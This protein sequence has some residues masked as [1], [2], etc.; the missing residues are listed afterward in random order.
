MVNFE[1]Q[2]EWSVGESAMDETHHEF[3]VCVNAMLVSDDSGLLGALDTFIE[4]AQRHFGEEDRAMS[5]SAYGSAGC[6]VDEHAAVLN[7]AFEVR[8]A[9]AQGRHDV[10]RAF[11]RALADWF[12]QHASVMDLGLARWLLQHRLGG[13]PVV[14]RPRMAAVA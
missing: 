11:A 1:W 6:H 12:P 8:Q 7:S 4:H 2:Q 13:A 9:L 3:V 14:L 5:A 10:V